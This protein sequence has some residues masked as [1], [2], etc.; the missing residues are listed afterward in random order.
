MCLIFRKMN[1]FLVSVRLWDNFLEQILSICSKTILPQLTLKRICF[2]KCQA[3]WGK[4]NLYKCSSWWSP[5]GTRCSC[6]KISSACLPFWRHRSYSLSYLSFLDGFNYFQLESRN[7]LN[8]TKTSFHFRISQNLGKKFQVVTS[9]P[10]KP[11]VNLELNTVE[12]VVF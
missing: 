3:R 12:F 2:R 8:F 4:Q 5:P 9:K 1:N 10:H 6:R 11:W 7:W